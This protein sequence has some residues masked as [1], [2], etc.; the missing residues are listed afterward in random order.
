MKDPVCQM[1]VDEQ[2]A[3]AHST[4]QGKTYYFCALGCQEAFEKDPGR[5]IPKETDLLGR[6][7]HSDK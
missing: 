1:D 7:I 2:S 3:A 4:Y 5:Y 6:K